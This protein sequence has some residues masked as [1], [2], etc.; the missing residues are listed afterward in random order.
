MNNLTPVG[1]VAVTRAG[2][3]L[4]ALSGVVTPDNV[5]NLRAT[6]E[7]LIVAEGQDLTVDLSAVECAHSVVLS[8][9]LCWQRLAV[10]RNQ[11]LSFS[12]V[13]ERLHSLAALSGLVDHL[14]GFAAHHA[15]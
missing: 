11:R 6:G 13:S 15:G 12:G 5:A 1:S 3:G 14:P 4:L 2:E 8:L 7:Q 10:S 9:L